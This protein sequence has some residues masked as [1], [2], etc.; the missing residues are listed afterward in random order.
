M[1]AV[2][3]DGVTLRR[4]SRVRLRPRARADIFDLALAGRVAEVDGV[5]E[6]FEGRVY[7]AVIL[8]GDPGR[9]F[10]S[11]A[12][13]GHR[14]FFSPEELQPADG[15]PAPGDA[16]PGEPERR[17]LV[18][19]IGNVFLADDG[20]GPGVIA[21]L[22]ERGRP[23]PA[24]VHAADF[25][26]RGMDLAYRLLEGYCAA[27][28]VD[29]AP[30]GE[31]PGTLS[32][33]EPEPGAGLGADTG[34]DLGT[35]RALPEAHGMDPVTVLALARTLAD[36]GMG[37][38]PDTAG[39]GGEGTGATGTLPRILVLGCEPEIRMTGEEPDV[40]V[41]LSEPVRRAVGEAVPLLDSLVESLR[42]APSPAP[43]PASSA[44]R[45]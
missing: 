10:G 34:A 45:G 12:Q 38:G 40:R 35:L 23:L 42:Q 16:G 22:R 14:F 9:D 15:P 30:R 27:V 33:I 44:E 3:V 19:G 6:D 41:G 26:I 28:L 36:T 31:P 11:A 39:G 2:T 4:G 25:G 20:F 17:V 5:E 13:I 1:N 21:A 8:E 7:V 18:A 43:S 29:A 32:V 37:T 24:H